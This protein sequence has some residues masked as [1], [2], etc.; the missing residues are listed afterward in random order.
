MT[1][2]VVSMIESILYYIC[3]L[4]ISIKILEAQYNKIKIGLSFLFF[5]PIIIVGILCDNN[6]II[7]AQGI[8]QIFEILLAKFCL[9]NVQI[10]SIIYFYVFLFL[11][12]TIIISCVIFFL[13]VKWNKEWLIELTVNLISMIMCLIICH[14]NL[15]TK[16]RQ[17]LLWIP[18]S[19]KRLSLS[20]LIFAS[21]LVV[22]ILNAPFYEDN[23]N[24]SE[25]IKIV[26]IILI[27]FLFLA[28]PNL[29]IYSMTNTNLKKL[30]VNYER[31]INAQ[32][33]HYALLSELNY[34]LRRFR[35]DCNNMC[36]GVSKLISDGKNEAALEMLDCLSLKDKSLIIFDTGNGI[37]DALLTD[38]Q[39]QADKINTQIEF[40]GA[41]PPTGIKPTELCVIFGNTIDNALEACE[42]IVSSYVKLIYVE[43]VCNSGFMFIKISNPVVRKVEISG[44]VPST[45]KKDKNNHGF[46]LYSLEKIVKQHRGKMS[47]ECDE[48]KFQVDI[49]LSLIF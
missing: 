26:L 25:A 1:L 29:I 27:V 49:D 23:Q 15:N 42:K 40:N 11:T 35:H 22:L 4:S 18:K 8:F 46:G 36:I 28:T 32:S 5:I 31:Q 30:T 33:E 24:W 43:C 39:K 19:I 44:N 10:T 6:I 37:V 14:T 48:N 3:M 21:I 38:K 13:S 7:F 45:T 9:R 47:F 17:M 34:E 20:L 2:V 41:V 16:V 12:N